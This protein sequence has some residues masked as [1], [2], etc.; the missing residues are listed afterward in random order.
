MPQWLETITLSRG[1]A[2]I[3]SFCLWTLG[4]IM[5]VVLHF[6]WVQRICSYNK[7]AC[8]RSNKRRK[9][10]SQNPIFTAKVLKVHK[11]FDQKT[12]GYALNLPQRTKKSKITQPGVCKTCR[13]GRDANQLFFFTWPYKGRKS[14]TPPPKTLILL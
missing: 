9:L 3:Q 5:N 6:Y 2:S 13:S 1:L 8:V 14:N 4:R 11:F 10:V 7:C 12:G